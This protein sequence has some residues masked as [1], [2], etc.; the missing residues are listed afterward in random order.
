MTTSSYR[1]C[2][3]GYVSH[4]S[5][6]YLCKFRQL[7]RLCCGP[8]LHVIVDMSPQSHRIMRES[9]KDNISLLCV[10]RQ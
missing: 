8:I 6:H 5:T 10:F 1:S 3:N 7:A 9:F 4:V 2:S